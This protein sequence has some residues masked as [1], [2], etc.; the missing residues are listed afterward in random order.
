AALTIAAAPVTPRRSVLF[1]ATSG[2][3]VGL[4]AKLLESDPGPPGAPVLL[5]RGVSPTGLIGGTSTRGTVSLV[6]L[7]PAGGGAVTLTSADPSLVQ[8]PPT[9][10]IPAGNSANSFTITTSPVVIGATVRIDATAGGVTK[11][12]FI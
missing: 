8:V 5:A 1:Q 11:S 6:M 7:A 4:H 2:P 12:Q 10:S 3:R 9:V